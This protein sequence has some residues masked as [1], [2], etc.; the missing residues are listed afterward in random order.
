VLTY[1]TLKQKPKE[2]LALTGLARREFDELLP[3]FAKALAAA[4]ARARPKPKK[5]QRAP[6]GGRKPGLRTVEDK[7]LF[8]LVYTPCMAA[9]SAERQ[10]FGSRVMWASIIGQT[11]LAWL[12]AAVVFQGGLLLG[13]G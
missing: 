11:G 1:E 6:G 7:L 3:A 13:L 12:L 2:L 5:R 8:V 10:E 4:E 9:I